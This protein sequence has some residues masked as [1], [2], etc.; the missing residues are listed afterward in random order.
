MESRCV[1]GYQPQG[2]WMLLRRTKA[3]VEY[4]G[5]VLPSIS[6]RP[7]GDRGKHGAS[8]AG[9]ASITRETHSLHK[10]IWIWGLLGGGCC[11]GRSESWYDMCWWCIR[12]LCIED[13]G[14]LRGLGTRPPTRPVPHPSGMWY[15]WYIWSVQ[16]Y[17]C[18]SGG[19]SVRGRSGKGG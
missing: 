7:P 19:R 1:W 16:L 14:G 15:I 9:Y 12:T 18:E 2:I 17:T 11:R 4:S 8:R 5:Q 13:A 6:I 10:S 3:V